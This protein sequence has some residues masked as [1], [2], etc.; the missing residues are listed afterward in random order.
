MN[1]I[2]YPKEFRGRWY[3]SVDRDRRSVIEICRIFGMSRETYY[4]WYRHDHG[5]KDP[6]YQSVQTQQNL[7][8]TPE[9]CA[10]ME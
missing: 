2:T 3:L 8:L 7:K 9:V 4:K 1:T 6:N 10:L 5:K